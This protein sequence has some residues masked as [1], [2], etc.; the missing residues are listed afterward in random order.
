MIQRQRYYTKPHIIMLYF[1]GGIS[2]DGI[3]PPA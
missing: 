3:I 1:K 2:K